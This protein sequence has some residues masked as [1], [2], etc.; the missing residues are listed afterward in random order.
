MQHSVEGLNCKNPI[1]C[2]ASSKILTPH[3]LTARRVYTLPPLVRG[4]DTLAGWRGGGGSIFWKKPDNALYSTYV[5]T[6]CTTVL[7]SSWPGNWCL[8]VGDLHPLG[9]HLAILDLLNEVCNARPAI[10]QLIRK[11]ELIAMQLLTPS[12]LKV[13]VASGNWARIFKIL[14]SSWIDSKES[15]PPAYVAWRARMTTLFLLSS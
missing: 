1:Q 2:L 9:S 6:L 15:I 3:E 14:R 12:H 8:I 5:S 7:N 10:S 11:T 13:M 4:E